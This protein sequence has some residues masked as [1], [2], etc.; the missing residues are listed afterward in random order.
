MQTYICADLLVS[1]VVRVSCSRIP[2]NTG[3]MKLIIGHW[4]GK[5][6]FD[7]CGR[8]GAFRHL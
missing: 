3:I 7:R 5:A 1:L 8:E 6:H 4:V 2:E